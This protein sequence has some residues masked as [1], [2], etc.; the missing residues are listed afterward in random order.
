MPVAKSRTKK[1][2]TPAAGA[3]A[4]DY[5]S[6]GDRVIQGH[7][8]V[9]ISAASGPVDVSINGGEWQSCREANGYF[10]FDWWPETTGKQKITARQ[11]KKTAARAC[12]VIAPNSN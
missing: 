6:E 5:P 4:I 7:Y 9:R 2:I 11:S 12:T 1:E 10:W 8:A 3:L